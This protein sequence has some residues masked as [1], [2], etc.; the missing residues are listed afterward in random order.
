MINFIKSCMSVF[1]TMSVI[2]SVYVVVINFVINPLFNPEKAITDFSTISIES[3]F[4]SKVLIVGFFVSLFIK[5]FNECYHC[6][7]CSESKV[8]PI[9][10]NIMVIVLIFC[11]E[12]VFSFYISMID[13]QLYYRN[14]PLNFNGCV[15][16][17]CV[18][19]WFLTVP[20]LFYID[21]LFLE[22]SKSDLIIAKTDD[23]RNYYSELF[24]FG[25]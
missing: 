15:S 18:P 19:V 12:L 4:M 21:D 25:K 14:W 20:F 8:H 11:I 3:L 1:F 2:I 7:S 9:F 13:G 23:V 24:R 16:L 17:L 6:K 22:I 5:L 10:K